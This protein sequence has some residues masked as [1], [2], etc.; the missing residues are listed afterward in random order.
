MLNVLIRTLAISL[1][2][3]FRTH[4]RSSVHLNLRMSVKKKEVTLLIKISVILCACA[5]TAS[6]TWLVAK[7]TYDRKDD[8]KPPPINKWKI[9]LLTLGALWVIKK[10]V[11]EFPFRWASKKLKN[12]ERI[13]ESLTMKP[14]DSGPCINIKPQ[15]KRTYNSYPRSPRHRA[16]AAMGINENPETHR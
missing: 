16:R 2:H 5:I 7:R 12:L 10:I 4:L 8:Q 14:L 1:K 15:S 9:A 3:H 6:V 11:M 13:Q